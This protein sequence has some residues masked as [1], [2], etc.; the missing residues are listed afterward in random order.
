M[1][2]TVLARR[3]VPALLPLVLIACSQDRHAPAFRTELPALAAGAHAIVVDGDSAAHDGTEFVGSKG[4]AY[5]VFADD[6][7][8]AANVIYRRRDGAS[9]WQRVPRATGDLQLAGALDAPLTIAAWTMPAAATAYRALL[10]TA[11]TSFTLAPDGKLTAAADGCRV[12]GT[13]AG[14]DLAAAA[15]AALNFSGCAA[16]GGPADGDYDGIAYL[17]PDA[18]N[19]AFHVV[20][21]NGSAIADFYAYAP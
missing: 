19:A 21:D 20:V 14:A 6:S 8:A 7:N 1:N 18:S 10:G 16:S 3:A 2:P 4:A 13:I 5:V 9:A 11:V 17:D 15:E 12:G